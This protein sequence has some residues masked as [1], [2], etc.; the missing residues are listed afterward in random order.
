MSLGENGGG[1]LSPLQHMWSEHATPSGTGSMI[2]SG[3]WG[4]RGLSWASH[5]ICELI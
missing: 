2:V 3:W 5:L 4:H 1:E